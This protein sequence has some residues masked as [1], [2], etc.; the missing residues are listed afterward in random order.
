MAPSPDFSST[1]SDRPRSVPKFG[2]FLRLSAMH[3]TASQTSEA[4]CCR[5]SSTATG[6]DRLSTDGRIPSKQRA[7]FLAPSFS[8]SSTLFLRS[9]TFFFSG[10]LPEVFSL[11]LFTK[12]PFIFTPCD[13]FFF[14]VLAAPLGSGS[15]KLWLL[16]R[17]PFGL[18]PLPFC[19]LRSYSEAERV[20]RRVARGP[21]VGDRSFSLSSLKAFSLASILFALD[22]TYFLCVGDDCSADFLFIGSTIFPSFGH[23]LKPGFW[24]ND[25]SLDECAWGLGIPPLV[26][27]LPWLPFLLSLSVEGVSWFSVISI[28][29]ELDFLK[30]K[31][32]RL[33]E[34]LLLIERSLSE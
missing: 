10:D 18:S 27:R 2:T 29:Q 12:T 15:S 20:L 8:F 13:E 32:C 9:F 6:S 1:K 17:I 19:C 28:A 30:G 22:S 7:K 3:V 4:N 21:F 23:R 5:A 11:P 33:A 16:S 34:E 25:E 31:R 26:L 24:L 14:I